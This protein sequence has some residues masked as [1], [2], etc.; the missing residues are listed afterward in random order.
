MRTLKDHGLKQYTYSTHD[1]PQS[2]LDSDW[3]LIAQLPHNA[4]YT[5]WIKLEA[6]HAGLNLRFE[7]TNI[8]TRC[9][10][11][12]QEY[13]TIK[14]VQEFEIPSWISGEGVMYHIP[15]GVTVLDIKYRET[16]YD[17]EFVGSFKCNDED[18]NILWKKATRTCYICMRDHFMDCPDRERAEWL[19][20]AV[21]Q[22]E[23]CFYAFD[24]KS[25]SIVKDFIRSEQVNALPGQNLI[26]HGE[27]GDWGYYLY[28]GDLDT[29]KKIYNN[30]KSYL[31]RYQIG[32]NGLPIKRNDGW[33]WYDWGLGKQDV[34]VIQ[35]AM[36]YSAIT[37]LKKMALAT[38]NTDDLII[39]DSKITS[40]KTN[41]DKVFWHDNGYRSGDNLDERANAM[42]VCAGLADYSK[43]ETI[44][45]LIGTEGKCS[46]YF[47]RWVLEALCTMNYENQAL[48][49]MQQRYRA[50]INSSCSSLYEY[51]NRAH[52]D[53][54]GTD[55][56]TY[57][58]LN[59]GW[60][61]PN[62]ILSKY[63]A[64]VE[65]ISPGWNTWQILPKEGFLT[66]VAINIV[67]VKGAIA[68]SLLKNDSQYVIEFNCQKSTR[69]LVGIP[70][71][72]FIEL[73][74]I[75]VNS[76]PL[77]R[78]DYLECPQGLTKGTPNDRYITFWAEAGV[79]KFIANGKLNSNK[80]KE[81]AVIMNKGKHLNQKN[82]SAQ[83]SINNQSYEILGMPQGKGLG[84]AKYKVDASANNALNGDLWTGWRTMTDQIPGMWF[85]LDMKNKQTFNKIVFDNVWAIHDSPCEISIFGS[86]DGESWHEICKNEKGSPA[87]MTSIS[88]SKQNA[89]FIK[90]IQDGHKEQGWSI[91]KFDVYL[92]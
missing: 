13:N 29:L 82:W 88:F 85:T 21:L 60:N 2:N 49:R 66:S 70:I 71:N 51:I 1:L 52:E 30:T 33:D 3:T 10:Q 46:P 61:V 32:D 57:T 53:K 78:G 28:T 50:Q 40:I 25:H 35:A 74:D 47:E 8:M 75:V 26:A 69:A 36:F 91:F 43:Y 18:F 5:A 12:I 87:G 34:I 15:A 4:Q 7:S 39:I 90:I 89:R 62:T 86:D 20:D 56:V 11:E 37:A 92:T 19:G 77:W 73:D 83:A 65:P 81:P 48:I 31:D 42:A 27:Y 63:I 16:G 17:T 38:G 44:A 54:E 23:E 9:Q 24:L 41:F 68:V 84:R 79:W 22:M 14:G 64:G 72:S 6:S 67:T 76:K 58:T 55:A 80:T 45:R 59:H